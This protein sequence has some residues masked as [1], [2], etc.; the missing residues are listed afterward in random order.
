MGGGDQYG[1]NDVCIIDK[2]S[3]EGNSCR[4]EDTI[5]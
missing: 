5:K 3:W 4:Q 1:S 2:S